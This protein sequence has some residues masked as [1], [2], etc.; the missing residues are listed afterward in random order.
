VVTGGIKKFSRSSSDYV[1]KMPLK[2][3]ENPRS[4]PAGCPIIFQ[5]A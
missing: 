5:T 2:N 3:L 4:I 1:S